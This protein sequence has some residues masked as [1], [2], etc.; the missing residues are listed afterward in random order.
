MNQVYGFTKQKELLINNYHKKSLANSM[1]FSG[2]K[3]IGKNTFIFNLLKE[4]F[5]SS[6]NKNHFFHH[7][8]LIDNNSHPNIKYLIRDYDD[9]LKKEKT[10][11]SVD[12]IRKLNNFFY[13]STLND[14]PKFIIIDSADDL[15]INASNSLLKIL[16]EPKKKNV[17]FFNFSSTFISVTNN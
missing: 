7:L 2:Q 12:Q 14:L 17:Y 11:I 8:N 6:V 13:E 15:N 16:E 1:I 3:G 10:V 4:I 5:K 9:K